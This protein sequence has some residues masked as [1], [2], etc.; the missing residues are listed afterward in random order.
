MNNNSVMFSV[1]DICDAHADNIQIGSLSFNS[2]GAKDIIS[3]VIQTIS[4]PD[5]NS[6]VKEIL[7]Q[8]GNNKVLII[9]AKGV[10]HASMIGDQIASKALENNWNGIIVNGFVRDIE[11]LKTIPIGIYA[12]GSIPKKTD[13]KGL[14]FLGVDVFIGGILIKTGNWVYLD[15]N[16]WVISKKEL[17]L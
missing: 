7:N 16:G 3:G 5:D 2:Y 9:D 13:K 11:I 6:L 15:S 10:N 17:E 4:C 8:P 14:G 1:P 12:K